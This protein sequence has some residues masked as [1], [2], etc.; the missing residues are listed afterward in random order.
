MTLH[1]KRYVQKLNG[2]RGER[3]CDLW[4]SNAICFFFYQ[5]EKAKWEPLSV[6][7]KLEGDNERKTGKIQILVMSNVGGLL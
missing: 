4:E 1:E 5:S 3:Y 2:V 6:L 7:S